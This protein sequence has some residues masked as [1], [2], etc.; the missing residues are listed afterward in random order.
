MKEKKI[1]DYFAKKLSFLQIVDIFWDSFYAKWIFHTVD[2][3]L[4]GKYAQLILYY[5]K[6]MKYNKKWKI[7]FFTQVI[8]TFFFQYLYLKI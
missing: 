6:T 1:P 7:V 8:I 3:Y 2:F 4:I 5:R